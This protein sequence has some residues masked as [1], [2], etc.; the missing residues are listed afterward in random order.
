MKY[1]LKNLVKHAYLTELNRLR[2]LL[3]K[4]RRQKLIVCSAVTD[5]YKIELLNG[6][7]TDFFLIVIMFSV[8]MGCLF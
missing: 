1:F 6:L 7:V 5:Y 4:I 8:M 3:Q 2:Y